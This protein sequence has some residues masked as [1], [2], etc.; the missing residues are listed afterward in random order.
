MNHWEVKHWIILRVWNKVYNIWWILISLK[1]K[2]KHKCSTQFNIDAI[3]EDEESLRLW[4]LFKE[5]SIKELKSVYRDLNIEFSAYEFES[6]YYEQ[7]HEWVKKM[8]EVG[9]AKHL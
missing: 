4:K 7:A 8:L 1:T 3:K 6:Q 5:L 9:L 2:K